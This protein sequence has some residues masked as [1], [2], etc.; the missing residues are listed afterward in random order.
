[1]D[2]GRAS[3]RGAVARYAVA[4]LVALAVVAVVGGLVLDRVSED[5]AV[6]EARRLATLAG[7][8]VVEPALTDAALGGRPEAIATLDRVVQERVLGDDVVRVKVWTRDGRIAYSDE[9]RLIGRRYALGAD[10]QQAFTTGDTEAEVADLSRP[11]NRFER[12]E[13]PLLE[14]YLPVRTEGGTPALFELYR[15]ESSVAASGRDLLVA[16]AP[17]LVGGLLLLWLIQVPLA[18]RGARR[19]QA[20]AEERERLL[21]AAL[22]SS[23][24][25]RRRVAADLHDGPVQSLAGLSYALAAAAQKAPEG[26]DPATVAAL[27]EGAEA[28][29]DGIRRLRA[30]VVEINPGRLH[31]EGLAAA[32]EDLAAPLR[33]RGVAVNLDVPA[34]LAL[35]EGAEGLLYRAAGEAL[36]NVAAHADANTVDVTVARR[37]G[38]AR[39]RVRDDGRGFDAATRARRRDEGHLGL[40]LVEDLA[41]HLGGRADVRSTPGEGTV[42]ELEV[43][44]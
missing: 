6:E 8:G 14:V 9:P 18:W 43:P 29:R 24:V 40:A 42:V 2:A 16:I 22:E 44:A 3:V 27:H 41:A 5:E 35:P 21:E 30:A 37:D 7:R 11:E 39:L 15:R 36:R 20:G 25:E 34:D 31:D 32:L 4:G 13:G 26:T 17:V 1:M 12:D 10:E 33:A 23:A 28:A 19:L 38:R